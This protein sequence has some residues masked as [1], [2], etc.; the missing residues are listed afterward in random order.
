MR[1]PRLTSSL[2]PSYNLRAVLSA[3]PARP[4]SPASPRPLHKLLPR[5]MPRVLAA[6]AAQPAMAMQQRASAAPKRSAA[7]GA[8]ALVAHPAAC[9][10]AAHRRGRSLVVRAG[11]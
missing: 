5:A 9:R 6:T 1:D 11:A 3:P 4:H 2:I 8:R 7:T 10:C